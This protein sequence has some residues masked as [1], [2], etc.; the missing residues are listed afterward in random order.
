MAAAAKSEII[1][2]DKLGREGG[3]GNQEETNLEDKA[4]AAAKNE[5]IKGDKLGPLRR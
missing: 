2:G 1:K 5:N 3:N 4:A